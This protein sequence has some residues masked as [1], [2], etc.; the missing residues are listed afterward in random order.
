MTAF[1]DGICG[2]ATGEWTA[3]GQQ[4]YDINGHATKIGHKEGEDGYY[5]KVGVYCVDGANIHGID[6][7]NHDFP[8]SAVFISW[9]MKQGGAGD[10]F[11]YSSQ[12]SVYIYQ[13]I[14]DLL[15]ARD[16]AGFW[17]YRLNEVKPAPGDLVCW[18]RQAGIDYDHQNNGDYAGHADIVVSVG[19]A[20]IDIIGGNVGDS[21]TRRTLPL[22]AQ[23]FL[24]PL[25]MGGENLFALMKDRI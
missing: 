4:T 24:T 20:S 16:A 9:V 17:C 3:R 8:W 2:I 7:R 14:R 6:G 19:A 21:V 10:R 18:G 22:N 15:A 25:A 13:A 11:R 23:G 5:Q 1:T 12:H